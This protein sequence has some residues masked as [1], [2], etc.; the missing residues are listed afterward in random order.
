MEKEENALE[1]AALAG[2]ILLENGAEISRVEE[3]MERIATH[4]GVESKNFFILSNGIF[5]SGSAGYA[6]VDFIPFKGAQL[7]RVVAVNQLS[8]EIAADKY[9]LAE[10]Q[11]KL[12]AI[13]HMRSKPKWEQILGSAL[14]SAGFCVIFG[15]GLLD[16]AAAFASGLLLWIFVA[17]VSAPYLGKTIGN[18]LGGLLTTLLCMA[19]HRVGF[20]SSLGN[21]IVG[22][23]IPLIPGVAFTNGIRDIA[24]EDYIAGFTRL[25][26]AMMIFFCIAAGVVLAF[27][28][29]YLLEGRVMIVNG[30]EPA[31]RFDSL[32]GAC[33]DGRN[34]WLH[35]TL[36]SSPQELSADHNRGHNRLDRLF[37]LLELYCFRNH[38]ID[39]RRNSGRGPCGTPLRRLV[40]D[41]R[42]RFPHYRT[43]SP[44]SRRRY[45]LDHFL[46]G[47]QTLPYGIPQ[48]NDSTW[49]YRSDRYWCG[50]C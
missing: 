37:A 32:P 19:F 35:H 38:R 30:T 13:R 43:I 28:F 5:T 20:G 14:G 9:T 16:A 4:Y 3:T 50:S 34:P 25:L 31:D 2:H 15:G 39:L 12:Q 45:F 18:L 7:E 1:V 27:G 42:N 24:D 36:R 46:P 29:D 33:G 49:S 44:G 10:A 48:R 8:R 47:F 6:K 26:D 21:M 40:Q 23:L 11:E 41:P 22:A 17:F